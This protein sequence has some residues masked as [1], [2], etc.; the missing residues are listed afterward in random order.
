[1]ENFQQIAVTADRRELGMGRAVFLMIATLLLWCGAMLLVLDLVAN[2][3]GT[4]G[5]VALIGLALVAIGGSC[6]WA[7][8]FE[9]TSWLTRERSVTARVP[10][11]I[12]AAF[13]PKVLYKK[14]ASVEENTQTG[15]AEVGNVQ[16][17]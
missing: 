5:Q 6:L 4:H 2:A 9:V 10:Q 3:S 8:F 1:M 17:D 14:G 11:L 13:L 15:D 16:R 7:D 12:H